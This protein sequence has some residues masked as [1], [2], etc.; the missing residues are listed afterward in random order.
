MGPI[1]TCNSSAKVAALNTKSHRCGL[2][3][4]E[5]SYSDPKDAV[6][7]AKAADEGKDP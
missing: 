1:E 4:I 6:W 3:P 2:E 7:H 5:T